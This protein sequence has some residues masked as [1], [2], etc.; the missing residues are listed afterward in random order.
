MRLH[1][2]GGIV[3]TGCM[4]MGCQPSQ[5]QEARL[6]YNPQHARVQTPVL[7]PMPVPPRTVLR[8]Q[9]IRTQPLQSLQA[10]QTIIPQE[11]ITTAP[12][13][14]VLIPIVPLEEPVVSPVITTVPVQ[15]L[16]ETPVTPVTPEAPVANA[17]IELAPVTHMDETSIP[18]PAVSSSPEKSDEPT[19]TAEVIDSTLPGEKLVLLDVDAVKTESSTQPVVKEEVVTVTEEASKPVESLVEKQAEESAPVVE[20]P[21]QTEQ[22]LVLLPPQET[23]ESAQPVDKAPKPVDEQLKVASQPIVSEH[24]QPEPVMT[25]KAPEPAPEPTPEPLVKPDTYRVQKGD[26]LWSIATRFYGSGHRWVDIARHNRISRAD[27]I[28]E[29]TV[30]KLP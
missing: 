7:H 23:Q 5:S 3:V 8:S 21:I 18:A 16:P 29:G 22:M 6:P 10:A 30:L 17:W 13:T 12:S 11:T 28:I 25:S 20:V 2:W 26:T 14:L 24:S 9:A 19:V 27:R 15:A 1:I 4:M